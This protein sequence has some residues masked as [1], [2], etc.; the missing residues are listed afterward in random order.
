MPALQFI[1]QT[2]T[3]QRDCILS[4]MKANSTGDSSFNLDGG[5]TSANFP[6]LDK[7]IRLLFL[8][9]PTH[10]S[11]FHFTMTRNHELEKTL[12]EHA[13]SLPDLKTFA[14]ETKG[15]LASI[16]TALV[17]LTKRTPP[18]RHSF[19]S[20]GDKGD[21]GDSSFNGS[22]RPTRCGKDDNLKALARL[23]LSPAS[24]ITSPPKTTTPSTI[25][26]LKGSLRMLTNYPC[27]Q[28]LS[29]VFRWGEIR[30]LKG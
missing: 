3:L 29:T 12:C 22:F 14:A 26:N 20:G 1:F 5:S 25:T 23:K 8:G 7:L 11:N 18:E 16:Q 24:T 17:E 28:P 2:N 13:Q 9:L 19:A 6:A 21:S 10:A 15:T 30:V 27:L 4:L